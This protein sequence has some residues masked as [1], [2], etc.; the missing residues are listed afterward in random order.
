MRFKQP[1][2]FENRINPGAR[3]FILNR[4]GSLR[5]HEIY[6]SII[7]QTAKSCQINWTVSEEVALAAGRYNR[8]A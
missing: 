4:K 1:G 6:G 3:H 5:T 7:T 8:S 2:S